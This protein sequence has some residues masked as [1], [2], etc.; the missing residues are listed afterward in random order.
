MEIQPRRVIVLGM[1]A[2]LNRV[3]T[4]RPLCVQLE[5]AVQHLNRL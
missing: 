1:L 2:N 3:E 4:L 5:T